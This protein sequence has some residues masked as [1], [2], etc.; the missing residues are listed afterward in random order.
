[1]ICGLLGEKLGHSYSPQI[2]KCLGDYSY[3]LYEK[4]PEELEAF[5][6]GGDF[7]GL[8]V[9]IPYKKAVLPYCSELSPQAK[10]LGAVNT[11][12]RRDDGTLIGHNTDY[13]GFRSMATN[14]GISYAGKKVLILGSG[15]AS[16]T[17]CSVMRELGAQVIVISRN[18][19]NNYTNLHMHSDCAVIVNATPVGM[20]PHTGISPVDLALFPK[21]EYV[22]DL[23]YNPGKT[24]LL[25]DAEA[26][27]IPTQNG[28]WMLVAQAAESSQWFTNQPM[29]P[30]KISQIYRELKSQM[31]NIV[32]I[33]MPGCGK[34][35][36]GKLLA[37][38][39]GKA[40]AD[41]DAE[42]EATA[43][44]TIPEI[45]QAKGEE[46]FRR[47]ETAALTKLAKQSACVIA[48]GGG[49]VTRSENLPILRQ[50]AVIVWVKRDISSLPSDGRPL[51]QAGSLEQMYQIRKPLYKCFS[52]ITVENKTTA[53]ETAVQIISHLEELL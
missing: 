28:L 38:R 31:L 34:S 37:Q 43:C 18:G 6:T 51:S 3:S 46:E 14:A 12:V 45:F 2:H 33:G 13:F 35:T 32:L 50:N 24:K 8:N 23:I 1:M 39:L 25:L 10:M 47:L 53:D 9:T 41:S 44:C 29:N 52:D 4:A 11:I 40:F 15:G 22:M 20:Y 27:G 48:T 21:L 19:E 36:I 30:D 7:H 26:R 49:C 5:L 42:I 16:N 17:V